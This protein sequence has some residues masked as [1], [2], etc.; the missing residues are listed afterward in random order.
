MWTINFGLNLNETTEEGPRSISI[1]SNIRDDPWLAVRSLNSGTA[2]GGSV[3][4]AQVIAV[5]KE[6]PPF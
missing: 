1:Q 3:E 4:A 5:R 6:A 2:W